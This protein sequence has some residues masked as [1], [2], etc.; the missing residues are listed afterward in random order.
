[1]KPGGSV[2]LVLIKAELAT[3]DVSH[4]DVAESTW[5]A[6]DVSMSFIVN[7]SSCATVGNLSP[8]NFVSGLPGFILSLGFL[9]TVVFFV[10]L[11]GIFEVFGFCFIGIT[12][13]ELI[14]AFGSAD[15]FVFNIG[16]LLNFFFFFIS[17]LAI[18][19]S[20]FSEKDHIHIILLALTV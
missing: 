1:M 20:V 12:F 10:R 7:P 5:P 6:G 19:C 3:V 13:E 17:I 18:F 9:H 14:T 11:D 15:A 2:A 4:I 8:N 16:A